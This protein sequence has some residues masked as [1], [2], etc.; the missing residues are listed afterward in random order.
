MVV[1][2]DMK[3]RFEVLDG[4]RGISI[5]LVLAGHLLPLGSNQWQM[6]GAVAATGMALF[7]I[8]SG[9][10]IT[11]ILIKNQNVKSFL[12]RRIMR[13]FPLAWS[14]LAVTF[15]LKGATAHQ[16]FSN[17]LFYA[18]WPPM[19]LT[20]I[21]SHYWSLC[22]EVQFYF[23][24]AF[25]VCLL[26]ERTFLVIPLFCVLVT[27]LRMWYGKEMVINTYFRI[28]EILAGCILAL[29]F[30][31]G[32]SEAKSF[33]GKLNPIVLFAV[34]IFSAHPHSGPLNYFRPYIAMLL[35]GSTLFATTKRKSELFLKNSILFYLASISY[36]LYI[37]HGV[38]VDTWLGEGD[39]T[40]KYLKR[41]ILFAAT[42]A[43]AH[44]STYYFESYWQNLGKKITNKW[45]A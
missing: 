9:F 4:W 39:K 23:L 36:A 30:N 28:D 18:N 5:S 42:F 14:V 31:S 12:V 27:A 38:L 44:F 17:F 25:L 37:I 45:N 3:N 40:V 10:L 15:F 26:K 11:N 21:N 34:L 35:V 16:W 20:E 24:I 33:I 8:L 2:P 13:I 1:G 19:G 41:P 22:V 32:Y 29:I 7:F 43:L 6:N